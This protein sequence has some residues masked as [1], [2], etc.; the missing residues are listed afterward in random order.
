M[1]KASRAGRHIFPGREGGKRDQELAAE[2]HAGAGSAVEIQRLHASLPDLP[3]NPSFVERY[4]G[5]AAACGADAPFGSS[6]ITAAVDVTVA[7]VPYGGALQDQVPQ[8]RPRRIMA[9]ERMGEPSDRV[10]RLFDSCSGGFLSYF[11]STRHSF[12]LH[13]K[14]KPGL[15]PNQLGALAGVISHF[16]LSTR[17]A[18]ISMPTGSGKTAV[19]MALCYLLGAKRAL[20]ITPSQLVRNQIAEDFRALATL[21]KFGVLPENI[22]CPLVTEA[23]GRMT[24]PA[25]WQ[26]LL[27]C[28]VVVTTPNSLSPGQQ[29][30]VPPPPEAFDLVLVD[31][32]HHS[33]A[34]TWAQL[35][36]AFPSAKRVLLTATPF[37]NDDQELE[38]E[39]VYTYTLR[40]AHAD[41]IFGDVRYVAVPE[42]DEEIDLSTARKAAEVYRQDRVDG[43]DH[44]LI[45]RTD[46]RK[47][48]GELERLYTDQ[49]GLKVRAVHSKLSLST[50][51]SVIA[52]LKSGALD[53]IVCVDML[54]EGFDLPQ[55]KVAAI[56]APHKSLAVTLQF[57]GRFTRLGPP[58]VGPEAKFIAPLSELKISGAELYGDDPSWTDIIKDLSEGRIRAQ[59]ER[60]E[61]F[62][63]FRPSPKTP[64]QIEVA[65]TGLTPYCHVKVYE[66][67]G[68]VDLDQPPLKIELCG[69]Q[70]FPEEHTAIML[71][72]VEEAPRWD[73]RDALSVPHYQLAVI[74]YDVT[75]KLL[76]VATSNRDSET[77]DH[78]TECLVNGYARRL[79]LP[80]LRRAMAG[81]VDPK[82]HNLGLRNKRFQRG[83]E[84]YRISAG[85]SVGGKL[86]DLDARN[87][88]GG[89]SVAKGKAEDGREELL[90]IST[91]SK[92]WSSAYLHVD[93]L[94]KWCRVLATKLSDP[95]RDHLPCPIPEL[96]HGQQVDTFP[97]G[98]LVA[99]WHHEA[100]LRPRT[101]S[102]VDS[103]TGEI[104]LAELPMAD[105][106]LE[107][108]SDE[109][110]AEL[111]RFYVVAGEH[112]I[113]VDFRLHPYPSYSFPEGQT[114]R[115][116]IRQGWRQDA[117][118]CSY[119]ADHEPTFVFHDMSHLEGD[120]HFPAAGD[121]PIFPMTAVEA[122]DW[123]AEGVCINTEFA[124]GD[125][126]AP[127]GRMTIHQFVE[128][129]LL[130]DFDVVYYDH[131]ANE[132]ADY[133]AFKDGEQPEVWLYHCKK[134]KEPPRHQVE[135]LHEVCGQ[136]VR[137]VARANRSAII[138]QVKRRTRKPADLVRRF[139]KGTPDDVERILARFTVPDIPIHVVIVQPG[140][141]ADGLN[142]KRNMLL[143]L[144][145]ARAYLQG[146]ATP[147]SQLRLLCS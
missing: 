60:E 113:G 22:R 11:T 136:A 115:L 134:T 121:H 95:A 99:D 83:A 33:P 38:A 147:D 2:H 86:S 16:T 131:A 46:R 10:D 107:V 103:T 27:R 144:G 18:L 47:R 128:T 105:A 123:A 30:V 119:L 102:V 41:G 111:L 29:G 82:V 44:R 34:R 49:V 88:R 53:G 54:G 8:P 4:A 3:E 59:Q 69:H 15:R 32:A 84:S 5:H 141:M 63:H 70:V 112:R 142:T 89:H 90:G 133:V 140:V 56:H 93:A 85:K 48:A 96:D 21:K 78:L 114:M 80:V 125:D 40:Q 39:F 97:V 108:A 143:L 65:L 20:V 122:V 24:S 106:D 13:P 94:V 58:D 62:K 66:V 75:S 71:W 137:S 50:I 57:I 126:P 68:D 87:Y 127:C 74:H 116:Q 132:M 110:T 124:S 26:A 31:E 118:F 139:K 146:M 37:R 52:D 92:V 17:P 79:C 7:S 1:P 104:V 138:D 81:W 101:L 55:L 6:W 100:Y 120:V 12:R 67:Y 23:T 109:C 135:D 42:G 130:P 43:W 61:Y 98:V 19:L 25:D 14:G 77:Y 51:K 45:V 73:S 64:Q 35:M 28:D 117:D 72:Y 76:F 36:A 91:S 129:R 9:S 145:G